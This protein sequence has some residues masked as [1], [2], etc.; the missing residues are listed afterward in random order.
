MDDTDKG[1]SP[2]NMKQAIFLGYPNHREMTMLL[3][4]SM[5]TMR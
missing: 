1:N 3:I 4:K 5:S 2:I